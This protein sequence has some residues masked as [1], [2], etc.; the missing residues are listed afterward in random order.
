MKNA[1]QILGRAVF[2]LFPVPFAIGIGNEHL[3]SWPG[4]VAYAAAAVLTGAAIIVGW[5]AF[6]QDRRP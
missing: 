2:F 6:H 5:A 1:A 4:Y 3:G